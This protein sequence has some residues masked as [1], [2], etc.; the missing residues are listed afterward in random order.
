VLLKRPPNTSA[1]PDRLRGAL[2]SL[3]SQRLGSA[4]FIEGTFCSVAGMSLHPE[5]ASSQAECRIGDA[6][7]MI[8]PVTGNGMS[9]AF[10]AAELAID[11]LVDYSFGIISWARTK[12][13]VALG[14]DRLFARRLNWARCL[15]ALMMRA[16]SL[17]EFPISLLLR[18]ERLWQLMFARTR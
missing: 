2:G 3:L 16:P 17:S 12:E 13:R 9:M 8:P 18:C 6:L 14:C 5:K 15:Q 11:P 1:N 7:T 10:E 4:D